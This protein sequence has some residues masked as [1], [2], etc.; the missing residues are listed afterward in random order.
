[1]N[2][3][4]LTLIFFIGLAAEGLIRLPYARIYRKS[5]IKYDLLTRLEK[6]LLFLAFMGM[7]FIPVLYGIT[8]LLN[9]ADYHLPPWAGATGIAL[10]VGTVWLFWRSHADL[11]RNWS[12]TLQIMEGHTLVSR[13]VYKYIRHPMYA[14]MWLLGISQPLLLQNWIAGLSSI[15]GFLPMYVLRVPRE[16]RLMLDHF[17]EDYKKYMENTG[18]IIPKL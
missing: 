5:T 4:F 2:N 14:S 10:M 17:G 16:E 15:I 11:G 13:G 18:R 3:D 9:F 12:P 1:M 6:F 7:F 8:P